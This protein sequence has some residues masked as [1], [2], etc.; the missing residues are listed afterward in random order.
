MYLFSK[1]YIL[2]DYACRNEK[3]RTARFDAWYTPTKGMFTGGDSRLRTLTTL[4]EQ[5]TVANLR[6]GILFLLALSSVLLFLAFFT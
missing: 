6:Y 5:D 3:L 4:L 1:I 2:L